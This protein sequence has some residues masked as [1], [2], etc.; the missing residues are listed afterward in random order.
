M[1]KAKA[2]E[3]YK[4]TC[5]EGVKVHGAIGFTEEL[6]LGLYFIRT[7]ASEFMLGDTGFHRERIAVEL[8]DYQPL[9]MSV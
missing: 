4:R 3:V 7:K 9:F 2:N 8:E 6:D 1:A 5:V